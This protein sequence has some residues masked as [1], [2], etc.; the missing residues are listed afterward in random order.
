M[1]YL[2]KKKIIISGSYNG[3]L[4][5]WCLTSFTIICEYNFKDYGY[6]CDLD[7]SPNEE[8]IVLGH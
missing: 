1:R 7:F 2:P 8:I 5:Y 3:I 6:I 4:K